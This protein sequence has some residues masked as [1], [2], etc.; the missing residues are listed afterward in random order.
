MALWLAV[1]FRHRDRRRTTSAVIFIGTLTGVH[2][3]RLRLS[4]RCNQLMIWFQLAKAR[5]QARF[6]SKYNR[7][8]R[9]LRSAALCSLGLSPSHSRL[10]YSAPAAVPLLEVA[11]SDADENV[12]ARANAALSAS[13]S[14]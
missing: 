14:R 12:R 3:A 10:Q 11:S 2:A 5:L 1:R 9:S 8:R 7:R 4:K 13:K 6:S